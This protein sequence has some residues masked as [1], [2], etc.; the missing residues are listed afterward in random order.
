MKLFK[1]LAILLVMVAICPA[2]ASGGT[3]DNYLLLA[4][5]PREDLEQISYVDI[6]FNKTSWKTGVNVE[7]TEGITLTYTSSDN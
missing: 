6:Y 3:M 1:F 4:P 5:D 2:K 7:S